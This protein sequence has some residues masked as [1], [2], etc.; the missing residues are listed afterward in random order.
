MKSGL[1]NV[2]SILSNANMIF[3]K[4]KAYLEVLFYYQ[5]FINFDLTFQL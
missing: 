4:E 3:L 5:N 2:F 1:Q